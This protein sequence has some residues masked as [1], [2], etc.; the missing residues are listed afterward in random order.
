MVF[1]SFDNLWKMEDVLE[2]IMQGDLSGG[3]MNALLNGI[4]F[5][6][7][8]DALTNAT[9]ES[10][11]AQHDR[12]ALLFPVSS[13]RN[14]HWI[15]LFINRKTRQVHHFDPYGLRPAQE[16]QYSNVPEGHEHLLEKFAAACT[17]SGLTFISNPTRYQRMVDGVNTCG[18]HVICRLRLAYLSHEQYAEL[19]LK[20]PLNPD[21]LVT[22]LTFIALN[23]D[24][25]DRAELLTV[26]SS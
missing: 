23:E 5:V 17:Q 3:E 14:G 6:T 16:E 11:F 13:L 24:Q 10:F 2:H 15:G 21:K 22:L 9:P 1:V 26:L 18:R 4:A 20:S 7:T 19:L 8:F 12:A 25:S